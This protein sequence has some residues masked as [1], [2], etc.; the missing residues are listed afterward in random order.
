VVEAAG[1][2]VVDDELDALPPQPA[3]A[4]APT[5][6]TAA[7]SRRLRFKTVM[8]VSVIVVMS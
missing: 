3:T 2:D 7:N 8:L 6:S 4:R 1:L 5:T